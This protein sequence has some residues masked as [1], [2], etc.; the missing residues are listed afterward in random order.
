M[1][2]ETCTVWDAKKLCSDTKTEL[3]G[4]C[5]YGATF[6]A[7]SLLLSVSFI[8]N[9][10]SVITVH[11]S[12]NTVTSFFCFSHGMVYLDCQLL[13]L[14]LWLCLISWRSRYCIFYFCLKWEIPCFLH[15]LHK[16]EV[17]YFQYLSRKICDVYIVS[18]LFATIRTSQH[19]LS[20]LWIP[21]T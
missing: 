18:R 13:L 12:L 16:C 15:V 20:V 17:T 10:P 2:G 3:A 8:L 14:L 1:L 11:G 5:P 21:I 6:L 19:T 4:K 9:F 7:R